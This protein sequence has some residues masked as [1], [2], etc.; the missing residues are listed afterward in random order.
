MKL[1][2]VVSYN[3]AAG[4]HASVMPLS[5]VLYCV[6]LCPTKCGF[7]YSG[8]VIFKPLGDQTSKSKKTNHAACFNKAM[9]N[10][11]QCVLGSYS[12][13]NTALYKHTFGHTANALPSV[14]PSSE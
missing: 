1:H 12:T 14:L 6:E 8:L 3:T 2:L 10:I 5:D 11:Y 9:L 13:V 4:C 7:V